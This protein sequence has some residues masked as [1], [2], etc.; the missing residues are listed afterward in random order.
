MSTTAK[1]IT[2]KGKVQGVFFRKH[3]KQKATD[4]ALSGW[5]KNTD[6]GNVEIFVQGDIN[7][8]EQLVEWCWQGPPRAEVTIVETGHAMHD[9]SFTDFTIHHKE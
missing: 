9:E 8:I 6:D 4:L 5:V 3:A 7:A 2:I 1:H